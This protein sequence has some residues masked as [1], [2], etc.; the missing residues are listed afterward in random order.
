[1]EVKYE[2]ADLPL[3]SGAKGLIQRHEPFYD[4]S[5]HFHGTGYG[6]FR[7]VLC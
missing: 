4:P 7:R 1:M 5:I 2:R 3:R 6:I